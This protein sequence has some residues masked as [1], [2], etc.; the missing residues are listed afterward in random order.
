[1]KKKTAMEVKHMIWKK[2]ICYKEGEGM[3]P[4][5]GCIDIVSEKM[6]SSI[7]VHFSK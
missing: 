5:Y 1:M 7:Y 4:L 6:Y 2:E 3:F